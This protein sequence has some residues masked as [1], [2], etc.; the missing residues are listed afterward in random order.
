MSFL[1][2]TKAQLNILT[3]LSMEES[4]GRVLHHC[5]QYNV[6]VKVGICILLLLAAQQLQQQQQ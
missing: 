2:T 1:H 4:T 6:Q 5:Y 3:R